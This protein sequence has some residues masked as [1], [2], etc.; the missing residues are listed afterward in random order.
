MLFCG[1]GFLFI[2]RVLAEG[3]RPPFDFPEGESELVSGFNTEFS[4]IL[5]SIISLREY[6]ILLFMGGVLCFWGLGLMGW[7]FTV[8]GLGLLIRVVVVIRG[9]CPRLRFDYLQILF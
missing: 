8:F 5:F 6:G 4:S 1:W 9:I 3:Q 2:F 7:G